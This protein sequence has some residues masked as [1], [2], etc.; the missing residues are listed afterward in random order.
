MANSVNAISA[1]EATPKNMQIIKIVCSITLLP[2]LPPAGT[3]A[4]QYTGVPV[5]I[6]E[7]RNKRAKC[8]T[9][10]FT[11]IY[12]VTHGENQDLH[13]KPAYRARH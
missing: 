11:F 7:G 9:F 10:P 6:D 8:V 1:T 13:A 12:N 5:R 2:L 4:N 3:G